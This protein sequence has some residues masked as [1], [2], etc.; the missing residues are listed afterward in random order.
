MTVTTTAPAP[1]KTARPQFTELHYLKESD[2]LR[3]Q[4]YGEPVRAICGETMRLRSGDAE[5]GT[6]AGPH[7]VICPRCQERYQ[8]RRAG[9]K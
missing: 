7:S 3:S 6:A 5:N 4:V 9:A 1:R 8:Q 2:I